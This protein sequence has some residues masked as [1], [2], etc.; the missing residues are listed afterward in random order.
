[1]RFLF[2]DEEARANSD[3]PTARTHATLTSVFETLPDH[4]RVA[5][6]HVQRGQAVVV[7]VAPFELVDCFAV[8]E[9]AL[10]ESAN[11]HSETSWA[12]QIRVRQV[13][14]IAAL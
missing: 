6:K 14:E 4:S 8:V 3:L 11:C 10:F 13:D 2:R 1:M 5:A 7:A 9:A 12:S